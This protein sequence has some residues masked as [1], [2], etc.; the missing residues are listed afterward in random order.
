LRGEVTAAP[1]GSRRGKKATLSKLSGLTRRGKPKRRKPSGGGAHYHKLYTPARENSLG[2][3]QG[4][5]RLFK[6]LQEKK[7]YS[8]PDS[9]EGMGVRREELQSR[10]SYRCEK[11]QKPLTRSGKES[12]FT[13]EVWTRFGGEGGKERRARRGW[14][15]SPTHKMG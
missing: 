7:T 3:E 15:A 13:W 12:G 6:R 8:C 4:S 10:K 5:A 11:E 9:R 14:W 1:K 2:K